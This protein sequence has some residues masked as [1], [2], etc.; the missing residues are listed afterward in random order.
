MTKVQQLLFDIFKEKS[1]IVSPLVGGMM[2][3]SFIVS[4]KDKKYVKDFKFN[5]NFK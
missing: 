2:N 3:Q 1:E 4:N 5:L